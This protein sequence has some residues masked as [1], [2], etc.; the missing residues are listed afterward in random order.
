MF[1]IRLE[2]LIFRNLP[3]RLKKSKIINFLLVGLKGVNDLSQQLSDLVGGLRYDLGFN[4]QTLLLEYRLT[5]DF[6]GVF[7]V[8]NNNVYIPPATVARHS[9][10]TSMI[11]SPKSFGQ[12]LSQIYRHSN[13][14]VS[15]ADFV[16]Q[17]SSF[18]APQETQIR[19]VVDKLKH[20]GLTYN[21][22]FVL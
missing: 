2:I 5:L 17:A 15:G 4:S 18:L 20:A 21:I 1:R 22:E 14:N 12:R 11:V 9:I 19:A 8:Q 6:G 7:L 13:P 16:I 10:G 3:T